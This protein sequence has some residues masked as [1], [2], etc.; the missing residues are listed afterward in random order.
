MESGRLAGVASRPSFAYDEMSREGAPWRGEDPP[1]TPLR[2]RTIPDRARQDTDPWYA[3]DSGSWRSTLMGRF[4]IPTVYL[5]LEPP[6]RSIVRR[7]PVSD[8]SFA[9]VGATG[10]RFPSPS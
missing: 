9:P 1:A 4:W 3:D 10:A 5:D 8:L 6:R 2:S 7:G